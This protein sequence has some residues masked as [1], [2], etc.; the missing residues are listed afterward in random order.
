MILPSN[1][2]VPGETAEDIRGA[3]FLFMSNRFLSHTLADHRRALAE[4]EEDAG[5]WIVVQASDPS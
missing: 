3:A 1:F 5:E 4:M 2:G